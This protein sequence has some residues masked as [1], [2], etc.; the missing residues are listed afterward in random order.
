MLTLKNVM[1]K[2]N[3]QGLAL[4]GLVKDSMTEQQIVF[5]HFR[6]LLFP[7]SK[8]HLLGTRGY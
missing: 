5:Y 6:L 1:S 4:H 8:V 7:L 2:E 3:S